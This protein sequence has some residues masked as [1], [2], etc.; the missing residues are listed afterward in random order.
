[1]IDDLHALSDIDQVLIGDI[2][3]GKRTYVHIVD[4]T[5]Y[6]PGIAIEER[7]CVKAALI[8]T[9]S[10]DEEFTSI[11]LSDGQNSLNIDL[12]VLSRL[13]DSTLDRSTIKILLMQLRATGK[14]LEI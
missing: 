6:L 14:A 5:A 12:I 3:L 8:D 4:L 7:H 2:Q 11:I 10:S 1:M 13:I 9:S